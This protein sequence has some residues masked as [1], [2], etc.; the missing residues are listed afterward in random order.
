L[1]EYFPLNAKIILRNSGN[2]YVDKKTSRVYTC[3]IDFLQDRIMVFFE[4]RLSSGFFTGMLSCFITFT[5]VLNVIFSAVT[6]NDAIKLNQVS[7]IQKDIF[8]TVFFISDAVGKIGLDIVGKVISQ[9]DAGQND[10]SGAEQTGKKHAN[11]GIVQPHFDRD[12]K[13]LKSQIFIGIL[14]DAVP[15]VNL[16]VVD[17]HRT[18]AF[19]IFYFMLM[20]LFFTSV[21]NAYDFINNKITRIY[22]LLKPAEY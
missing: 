6:V 13:F 18:C 15:A 17:K 4:R 9:K 21:K 5:V 1:F 14:N 10:A 11:D 7:V 8:A 20:L 19:F 2:K 12:F 16:K 22:L 3:F